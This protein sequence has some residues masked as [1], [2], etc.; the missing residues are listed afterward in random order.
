MASSIYFVHTSGIIFQVCD[1]S[2]AIFIVVRY[3]YE[4]KILNIIILGSILCT[5]VG[6][7]LKFDKFSR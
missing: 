7:L 1:F 6:R 5:I 4:I 3:I 2:L